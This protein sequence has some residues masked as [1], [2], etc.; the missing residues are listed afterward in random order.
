MEKLMEHKHCPICQGVMPREDMFCSDECKGNYE[1]LAKKRKRSMW[2]FYI[3]MGAMFA[4][5]LITMF[6]GSK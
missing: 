3:I 6:L 5:L 2:I 4:Y 1:G